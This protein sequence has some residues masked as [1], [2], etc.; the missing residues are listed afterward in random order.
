MA[1]K[2]TSKQSEK[3]AI[4]NITAWLADRAQN[5]WD[6]YL[7]TFMFESLKCGRRQRREIMKSAV[8]QVFRR[9]LTRVVRNPSKRS[10]FTLP[11]LA[12]CL[13]RPVYKRQKISKLDALVNDGDHMHGILLMPPPFLM[14]KSRLRCSVAEHFMWH[15]RTYIG[16]H[17]RL[18]RI[19]VVP[20]TDTPARAIDYMAKSLKNSV[21]SHDDLIFLPRTASEL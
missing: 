20:I 11:S 1:I 4:E 14:H 18:A 21:A 6:A 16:S 3:E 13:D 5:G 12:T 17:T 15:S 8:E 9:F 10:L 2:T 19:D 7:M